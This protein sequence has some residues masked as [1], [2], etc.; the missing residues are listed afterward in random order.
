MIKNV[1]ILV[2][3][4]ILVVP[5]NAFSV[6]QPEIEGRTSLIT[7]QLLDAPA[8]DVIRLLT[9]FGRVQVVVDPAVD[10]EKRISLYLVR[11]P[12]EKALQIVAEQIGGKVR[13][14]G[15]VF[16]MEPRREA[17]LPPPAELAQ[18]SKPVVTI[19]PPPPTL[20]EIKPVP[21]EEEPVERKPPK[22]KEVVETVE[23]KHL[24]AGLVALQ[25][26]GTTTSG[27]TFFDYL[28]EGLI[29][30]VPA[31]AE[32]TPFRPVAP[33]PGE[34]MTPQLPSSNLQSLLGLP[35]EAQIT[36]I[37]YQF[38]PPGVAPPG[39]APGVAP[40]VRPG[41]GVGAL[42]ALLPEGISSIV[43]YDLL[44]MLIVRG[45][46][47]AIEGFKRI[48]SWL[49]VPPKQ[50][51]IEAQFVDISTE[52]EE[53][54]GIDWTLST[55]EVTAGVVGLAAG[56]VLTVRYDVGR[57]GATLAAALRTGRARI[58]NA[59]RI[60]TLNNIPAVIAIATVFPIVLSFT[61]VLPGGVSRTVET[62]V[63]FPV[64]SF[65]LVLPTIHADDSITVMVIPT[66]ADIIGTVRGP[67]GIELPQFT[68]R[69]LSTVI[70][71]K[72]GESIVIGGLITRRDTVSELRVPWISRLPIIG[73]LFRGRVERERDT[74]ILIFITPRII[75][76]EAPTVRPAARV[77]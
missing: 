13:K 24:N 70:R 62:V 23:F 45:T 39:M 7:V 33:F 14:E 28:R 42:G 73:A 60:A 59:P 25:F 55:G 64:T 72:D 8:K 10:T 56:G 35:R 76:T 58:V 37:R 44:N 38:A 53:S 43:A 47:E 6:P 71:V 3:G 65:L 66:L 9:M 20:P 36:D 50:V 68:I 16:F 30:T 21:K 77:E 34:G 54:M 26:G 19:P 67:G 18:P 27:K 12:I 51:L 69:S 5:L 40:G 1:F 41:V 75:R 63:F 48:L 74:E 22:E 46:P 31:F 4:L 49:D 17:P 32:Q 57:F 29:P 2:I 15:E 52:Y 11:Q 61:Y